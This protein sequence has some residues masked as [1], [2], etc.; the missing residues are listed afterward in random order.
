[1]S[2]LSEEESGGVGELVFEWG[3]GT[4]LEYQHGA[5]Q[6]SEDHH[7]CVH[8][9]VFGYVRRLKKNKNNFELFECKELKSILVC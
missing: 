7:L 8:F 1:M 5:D 4:L 3:G 6:T 2:P 9:E